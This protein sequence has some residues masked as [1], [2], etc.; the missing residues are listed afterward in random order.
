MSGA[1][2]TVFV[3]EDHT[4]IREALVRLLDSEADL[5]A[6]GSAGSKEGQALFERGVGDKPDVLVVGVGLPDFRGL[7]IL[8][9]AA[10]LLPGSRCVALLHRLSDPILTQVLGAGALACVS[11]DDR[12]PSFLECIRRAAEGEPYVSPRLAPLLVSA[13]AGHVGPAQ[14]I[15]G[16][17]R[18][19]RQ[20]LTLVAEGLSTREIAGQL[21]LSPR[22]VETHRARVMEKL[23]VRRTS[24]LIRLAVEEGLVA[25]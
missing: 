20:V 2:A 22:T 16:L 6:L 25:S 24:H 1:V 9:S 8:Q 23:H 11:R 10:E 14:G 17:S 19:E 7:R 5:R 18:R 12:W 13:A 4:L 3:L 21:A 15:S